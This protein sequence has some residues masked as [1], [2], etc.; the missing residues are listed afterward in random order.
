MQKNL[1]PFLLP[2]ILW[3]SGIIFAKYCAISAY[4]LFG[5]I[6]LSLLFSYFCIKARI[7]F[8]LLLFFLLSALNFQQNNNTLP[9]HFSGIIDSYPHIQQP[10][11]GRIISE[12]KKKAQNNYFILSLSTINEHKVIGNIQLYTKQ[13]SL[14]YGDTISTIAFINRISAAS[15][16]FG[17]DMKTYFASKQISAFGFTKTIC[18]VQASDPH[19]LKKLIIDVRK[20]LRNRIAKRCGKYSGF[21]KA[22]LIAER[23]DLSDERTI[24]GNAGLSHLLAVSGLHVAIIALIIYAILNSLLPGRFISRIIAIFVLLFYAAICQFAPSVTRAVIMI[25]LYFVSKLLS[26]KT[27]IINILSISLL[28]IT[29]I[30]PNQLFSIGLQMSFAAVLTL[31]LFIP[32]IPLIKLPESNQFLRSLISI[33]NGTILIMLSSAVLSL[34]LA[35]LTIYYFNQ[36]NLNGIFANIIGIPIISLILSLA[37]VVISVPDLWGILAIYQHSFHFILDIFYGWSNFTAKLI[38]NWKFVSINLWQVFLIYILLCLIFHKRSK[39]YLRLI[40]LIAII[41]IFWINP[42]GKRFIIT[43]FDCGLGDLMLI[44]SSSGAN[45]LIDS[46]PTDN[47]GGHFNNSALP[48]LKNKGISTLDYVIIT[49]AHADHYGGLEAVIAE[50]K[51]NNIL[52]TDEFMHRYIWSKYDSLLTCEQTNIITVTDTFSLKFDEFKLQILHPDK[53]Y[54]SSNINNL[55]IVTKIEMDNYRFLFMGDAEVEA[56]EYLLENYPEF[57]KADVLKLGHHGSK[58]ASCKK[59]IRAVDPQFG[60]ICT[61][62]E[63]RFDFPHSVTMEKFG[64]LGDQLMVTGEEGA[65]QFMTID[66]KIAVDCYKSGKQFIVEKKEE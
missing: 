61:A 55:S 50:L 12:V 3:I 32:R 62:V 13:D 33:L 36:F 7:T 4:F 15:N 18:T 11:S 40:S 25:S 38:L 14:R 60:I 2:V 30:Q 42:A 53:N 29:I 10:I 20:Y 19:F 63:N 51:I 46:G 41:S 22:I 45:I 1:S 54:S 17:F 31:A 37:I 49:H 9:N 57:L 35:P 66:D 56:E 48:Y 64:Y 5:L 47:E 44:E 58:T 65:I 28:L 16:P 8:L 27:D 21:I 24:L 26:R 6:C 52:L 43:Y 34:F 39:Y 23:D 59:F